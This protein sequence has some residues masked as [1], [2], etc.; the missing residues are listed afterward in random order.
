MSVAFEFDSAARMLLQIAILVSIPCLVWK[1]KWVNRILPLVVVEILVG[2]ALGPSILGKINPVV[3]NGL[4]PKESLP[5]M[6][7][8]S[9]MAVVFLGLMVGMELDAKHFKGKGKAFIA[10]SLSS[11]LVPFVLAFAVSLWIF[12]KYPVFAGPNANVWTFALAM[13]IACGVTAL[14]VLFKTLFDLKLLHSPVGKD[15]LGFASVND[16]VLWILVAILVTVS[17]PNASF[18]SVAAILVLTIAFA[19]FLFKIVKPLLNRM[20]EGGKLL[21]IDEKSGKATVPNEQMIWI[22]CPLFVSALITQVI[23]VHYL[24]GALLYGLVIPKKIT[25]AIHERID[26]VVSEVLLPFFFMLTGLKTQFDIGSTEVWMLFGVMTIVSTVGKIAGTTLPA[27]AVANNT[28]KDSMMLGGLMNC[29][30]LMEVIVL[31]IVLA[32]GIISSVAFSA[33]IMMALATTAMTKPLV[34][35]VQSAFDRFMETPA[36]IPEPIPEE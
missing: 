27:R 6:E 12:G 36:N 23:G 20:V 15:S 28:W 1:M 14:P 31:N 5:G 9:L 33:M 19:A 18:S 10:V 4:F 34:L 35:M 29:K 17:K 30:G 21:K 8:V 32:G 2:V 24:L 7:L 22:I 3:F 13:G 16:F 26:A 11:I 25:T